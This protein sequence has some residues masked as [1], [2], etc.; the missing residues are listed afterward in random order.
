MSENMT[1]ALSSGP[2]H[3]FFGY[4][5]VDVWDPSQ[6]YHLA[7]ETDFDD[8]RPEPQDVAAVGLI[9]RESG[10]FSAD[11]RWIVCDTYP[12]HGS[13]LAELMLYS[14]EEKRKILLG[15]FHHDPQYKNDIRGDLHP[16]WSR[17]GTTVRF[18][19]VHG[20]T[21]KIYLADVSDIV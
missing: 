11:G 2:K 17:N 18:D 14:I 12:K 21:R 19:S 4:Y 1:T 10:L 6:R 3:H 9:D 5:G 7:L 16:R 15:E 20:D 8:H 13:R